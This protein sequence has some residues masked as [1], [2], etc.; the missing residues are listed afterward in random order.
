[1]F[2]SGFQRPFF[3]DELSL[4]ESPRQTQQNAF[5]TT[6]TTAAYKQFWASKSMI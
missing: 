2:S 3:A 4:Q 1:V 5:Q 6:H